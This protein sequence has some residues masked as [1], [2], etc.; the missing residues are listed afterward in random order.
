MAGRQGRWG[1]TGRLG[2]RT[3]PAPASVLSVVFL[4]GVS[5]FSLFID[6]FFIYF[7]IRILIYDARGKKCQMVA[8]QFRF[9]LV[10]YSFDASH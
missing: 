7:F 10:K 1:E 8:F 3:G 9:P 4:F 5:F 2:G 6:L